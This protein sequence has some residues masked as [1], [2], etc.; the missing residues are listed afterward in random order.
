MQSPRQKLVI[1]PGEGVKAAWSEERR[2]LIAQLN[3]MIAPDL[4]VPKS[5][6]VMLTAKGMDAYHVSHYPDG[7]EIHVPYQF[8]LK[9]AKK[10]P[11]HSAAILA[12]EYGHGILAENLNLNDRFKSA[13]ALLVKP[14]RALKRGDRFAD[15]LKWD[16]LRNE[17]TQIVQKAQ[18]LSDARTARAAVTTDPNDA[19]LAATD[20]E[21]KKLEARLKEIETEMDSLKVDGDEV[22]EMLGAFHEFFADV[23][24]VVFYND[25]KVIWR[26][27]YSPKLEYVG[28]SPQE[29]REM[30]KS[31]TLRRFDKNVRIRDFSEEEIHV[32]LTPVRTYAWD[33]YLNNPLYR[34]H[35]SK[36]LKTVFDSIVDEVIERGKTPNITPSPA[37]QNQRLI[38]R[39]DA[40]FAKL[41]ESLAL[42]TNQ[43][44]P[45]SKSRAENVH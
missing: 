10:H 41:K 12:H 9:G 27:L 40:N 32:A 3:A 11:I 4:K 35:K 44:R 36:I 42:P 1:E 43:S 28:M 13:L 23:V 24:A 15:Y 14:G 37:V 21:L 7:H 31:F 6:T 38:D 25:P 26:G 34:A 20:A 22:F 19:E 45:K 5:V 8:E 18:T 30:F 39:L 16:S 2:K 17:A 33:H 29:E